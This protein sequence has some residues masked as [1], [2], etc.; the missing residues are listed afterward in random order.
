M[1]GVIRGQHSVL[2][3]LAAFDR[4]VGV[5]LNHCRARRNRIGSVT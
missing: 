5:N 2:H 1:L 4:E 3:R